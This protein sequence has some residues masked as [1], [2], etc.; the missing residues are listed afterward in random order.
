MRRRESPRWL[1]KGGSLAVLPF[2]SAALSLLCGV[3]SVPHPMSSQPWNQN[4][5]LYVI[6]VIRR[7]RMN[8]GGGVP[9]GA[10]REPRVDRQN[11][12][13]PDVWSKHVFLFFGLLQEFVL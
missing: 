3:L 2:A 13:L 5:L 8:L 7:Y 10:P 4:L 12:Q 9:A 11:L 6:C 1:L